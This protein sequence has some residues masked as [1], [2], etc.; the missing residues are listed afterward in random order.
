MYVC[1]YVYYVTHT[2]RRLTTYIP[3]DRGPAAKCDRGNQAETRY[4]MNKNCYSRCSLLAS[5]V[6]ERKNGGGAVHTYIHVCT[7]RS[8]LLDRLVGVAGVEPAEP[9]IAPPIFLSPEVP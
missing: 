9:D 2:H 6:R 5:K 8:A 7:Y 3:R 1:M 4:L